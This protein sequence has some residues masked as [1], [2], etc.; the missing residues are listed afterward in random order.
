[1]TERSDCLI[2]E[3]TD[4]L[5]V[6]LT[7]GSRG[8]TRIGL[9]SGHRHFGGLLLE[10]ALGVGGLAIFC[11]STAVFISRCRFPVLAVS[12]NCPVLFCDPFPVSD[13]SRFHF[14][15]TSDTLCS[16]GFRPPEDLDSAVV[17]KTGSRFF[18]RGFG[19]C[20]LHKEDGTSDTG[21]SVFFRPFPVAKVSFFRSFPVEVASGPRRQG[22]TA[23]RCS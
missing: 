14:R 7:L 11:I 1:M 16:C 6:K 23:E 5:G 17:L 22:S 4:L 21:G 2:A 3:S 10:Q 13:G 18:N 15:M 8:R 19:G 9:P 20:G 12:G